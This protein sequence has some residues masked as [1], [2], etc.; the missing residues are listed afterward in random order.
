[1]LKNVGKV[2]D[3]P[4]VSETIS[5]TYKGQEVKWR[6]VFY[7]KMTKDDIGIY[8]ELISPNSLKEL[9]SFKFAIL[10]KKGEELNVKKTI[11]RKCD[12]KIKRLYGFKS[13]I[14]R[15]ELFLRRKQYYINKSEINISC[16]VCKL[17]NRILLVLIL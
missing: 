14:K 9:R 1:M 16:K 15:H 13:F 11:K 2:N 10:D 3:R 8:L 7:P 12:V 5:H 17:R 6:V 4:F